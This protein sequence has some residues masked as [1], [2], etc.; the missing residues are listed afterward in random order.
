MIKCHTRSN[1]YKI[2]W[3]KLNYYKTKKIPIYILAFFESAAKLSFRIVQ[4]ICPFRTYGHIAYISSKIGILKFMEIQSW[5][6][7]SK[8][9]LI[10]RLDKNTV[11]NVFLLNSVIKA[12]PSTH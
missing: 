7:I 2:E 1:Y 12:M 11:R 9:P 3:F 10:Y 5:T 6:A 4:P 8:A